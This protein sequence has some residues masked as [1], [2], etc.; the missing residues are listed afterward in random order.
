MALKLW[1]AKIPLNRMSDRMSLW[2]ESGQNYE[3]LAF[4]LCLLQNSLARSLRKSN[5]VFNL[6]SPWLTQGPPPPLLIILVLLPLSGSGFAPFD[7]FLGPLWESLQNASRL[8]LDPFWLHFR[9]RFGTFLVYFVGINAKVT[10]ELPLQREL[11]F[12]G[13]RANQIHI[14][15]ILV[16]NIFW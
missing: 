10:I 7:S 11:N 4:W 16:L 15:S 6:I 12:Q 3:F 1:N 5:L 14:F 8:I 2:Q 9:N 13:P